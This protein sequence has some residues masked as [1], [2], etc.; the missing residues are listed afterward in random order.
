MFAL[1][2]TRLLQK[3]FKCNK[4]QLYLIYSIYWMLCSCYKNFITNI[5]KYKYIASFIYLIHDI[6][7]KQA[8]PCCKCDRYTDRTDGRRREEKWGYL[9]CATLLKNTFLMTQKGRLWRINMIVGATDRD[10]FIIPSHA[11]LSSF[12]LPTINPI[13]TQFFYRVF[14]KINVFFP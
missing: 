4:R 8:G 11:A 3:I 9:R 12:S 2:R 6:L 1:K 5:Y 13:F 10:F 7:N 14:I